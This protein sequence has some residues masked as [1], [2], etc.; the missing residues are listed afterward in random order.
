MFLPDGKSVLTANGGAFGRGYANTVR[1][2]DAVAGHELRHFP[3]D[4]RRARTLC[5]AN[6][7]VVASINVDDMTVRIH[8]VPT[9]R[10]LCKLPG[11]HLV[12]VALSADGRRLAIARDNEHVVRILE[13]STG[14]EQR[15]FEPRDGGISRL[16]FSPDGQALVSESAGRLGNNGILRLWDVASGKD[17]WAWPIAPSRLNGFAFS[18]DSKLLAT[19]G[20][21]PQSEETGEIRLWDAVTGQEVHRFDGKLLQQYAVAFTADGRTLAT[22]GE[23]HR[24]RLWEVATGKLRRILDGHDGLISSLSSSRDSRRLVSAS[25]DGTALIWDLS[26]A[27]ARLSPTEVSAEWAA[28]AGEDAARAFEAITRLSADPGQTIPWLRERLRP[29]ES[30]D[31]KT[32]AK[33][34]SDLG[35]NRFSVR[36]RAERELAKLGD[37]ASLALRQALRGALSL[38]VQGRVRPLIAKAMALMPE[39]LQQFRAVEALERIDTEESRRVLETLS[40]GMPGARLTEAARSSLRRTSLPASW[41]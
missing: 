35:S 9:G 33:L 27:P 12:A 10:E 6:G 31:S 13:S 29:V 16:G 8:D 1:V 28:L 26:V 36:D 41:F 34:I 38:E 4:H 37:R 22:G 23:D 18:P 32:I 30:P 14:V 2:W 7:A 40:R 25:W 11:A 17:R 24:V 19:V 21:A 20:S 3:D 5:S 39:E 15:R